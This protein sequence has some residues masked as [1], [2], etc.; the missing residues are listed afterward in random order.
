MK[1]KSIS[2]WFSMLL[3]M[4]VAGVSSAWGQSLTIDEFS[5]KPGD[6][7]E[8]AIKLVAGQNAAFGIQ[9]DIVLS[10]GLS[11]DGD[12]TSLVTNLEVFY[13][14]QNG[15]IAQLSMKK[16]TTSATGIAAGEIIKMKVKASDTFNGGTITLQNTFIATNID[17]STEVSPEGVI[18]PVG[19]HVLC[20]TTGNDY[21]RNRWC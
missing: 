11:L 16:S 6:S 2:M 7:K 21:L 14:S 19:G 18:V 1:Y 4:M 9:T 17:G 15:R 20:T 5:L 10:E 3:V 8:V 12:P 13:N